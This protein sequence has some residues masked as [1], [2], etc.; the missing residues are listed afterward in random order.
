MLTAVRLVLIILTGTDLCTGSFMYTTVAVLHR[1]LSVARMLLHWLLTFLGN[2]AGALFMVGVIFGPG[3]VF[4]ADPF[5][6]EAILFATKKQ[7]KPLFHEIFLRG[8][9]CNWLVCLACFLGMQGRDLAS[10]ILGIYWPVFAFVSLGFDHVA[11]NMFFVP[12]GLWLDAPGLTVG[13]YVWKGVVPA[14]LGNIVGGGLFCGTFLWFLYLQGQEAPEIDG[15]S[16]HA[17]QHHHHHHGHH[18]DEEKGENFEMKRKDR[19]G[20]L[21]QQQVKDST[22][23]LVSG[24]GHSERI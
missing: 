18:D 12:L 4:A 13:L 9:G 17:Y 14:L 20:I 3:G 15:L 22:S 8:I 21:R 1:R 5:K 19:L 6:E 10:K 24:S 23:S 2:L 7:V 16:W 11:A